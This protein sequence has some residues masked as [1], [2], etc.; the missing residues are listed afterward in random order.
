MKTPNRC[1]DY[2]EITKEEHIAICQVAAGI[3]S[4]YQQKLA[5]ATIV[6]KLSGAYEQTFIPESDR[7]SCFLQ[8]RGFVGQQITKLVNN[9]RKEQSHE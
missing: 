4:E 7:E 3:A 9:P 8:G 5:L 1:F 2:P 6:K